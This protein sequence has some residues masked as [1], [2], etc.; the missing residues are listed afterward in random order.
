VELSRILRSFTTT[1]E[2]LTVTDICLYTQ[3]SFG[4]IY[5]SVLVIAAVQPA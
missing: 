5:Q 4:V 2:K 1:E 3:D